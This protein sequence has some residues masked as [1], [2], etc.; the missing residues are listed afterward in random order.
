MLTVTCADHEKGAQDI[1]CTFAATEAGNAAFH[2][3][4]S[5]ECGYRAITVEGPVEEIRAAC[6][7]AYARAQALEGLGPYTNPMAQAWADAGALMQGLAWQAED[8]EVALA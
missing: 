7:A 2:V 5:R 4:F 3:R 6:D 1:C 8:A